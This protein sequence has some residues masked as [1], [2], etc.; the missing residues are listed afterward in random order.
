[1]NICC[2][3]QST[4]LTLARPG[5][6]Q[7]TTRCRQAQTAPERAGLGHGARGGAPAAL[8]RGLPCCLRAAAETP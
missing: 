7:P 2:S 6:L 1:M 5:G 3:T 8:W 4:Q